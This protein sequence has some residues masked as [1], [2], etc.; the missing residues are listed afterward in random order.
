[1]NYSPWVTTLLS[2]IAG[3]LILLII[4]LSF[5]PYIFNRLITVVK[6]R[7]EAAHLMLL[8][9]QYEQVREGEATPTLQRAREVLSRFN[10]QN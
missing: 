3:P 5:G 10:E 2:T 6:R 7:L 8:Q 4:G 1:F 9:G